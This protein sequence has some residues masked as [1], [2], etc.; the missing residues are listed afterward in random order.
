METAVFTH[1]QCL[2]NITS[3]ADLSGG[4]DPWPETL[5]Q[6]IAVV[7]QRQ[8][9]VSQHTVSGTARDDSH[10]AFFNIL[11]AAGGLHTQHL[12]HVT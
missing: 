12:L 2:L 9:T 1:S 6:T 11:S 3:L 8:H 10:V 4:A 7:K 5:Q